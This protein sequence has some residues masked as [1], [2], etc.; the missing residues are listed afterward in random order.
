MH[1]MESP[2][3]GLGDSPGEEA[4]VGEMAAYLEIVGCSG[5]WTE[6]TKTFQQDCE[7]AGGGA[8]GRIRFTYEYH[9]GPGETR[10][11]AQEDP[12][13]SGAYR[14]ADIWTALLAI[15]FYVDRVFGED[16]YGRLERQWAE[17]NPTLRKFIDP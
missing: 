8:A 15:A 12:Y 7:V 10:M 13:G 1:V 6:R 5:R 3:F 9:E 14:P 17:D 4:P 16:R 2:L 11:F